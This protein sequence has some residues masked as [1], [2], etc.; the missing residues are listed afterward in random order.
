MAAMG[1]GGR[2][3]SEA[4][5]RRTSKNTFVIALNYEC[6]VLSL[7]SAAFF[8]L[9]VEAKWISSRDLSQPNVVFAFRAF[10]LN[11][12][13]ITWRNGER[14]VGGCYTLSHYTNAVKGSEKLRANKFFSTKNFRLIIIV[15]FLSVGDDF[16]WNS[17]SASHKKILSP[18]ERK[19]KLYP[20]TM[21]LDGGG[22][23]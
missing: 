2:N 5:N 6:D 17:V 16:V 13:F 21:L 23:I 11:K 7:S 9:L 14:C 1:E 15:A 8:L 20:S 19:Q 3:T 4:F 18:H 22:K 12:I 10:K